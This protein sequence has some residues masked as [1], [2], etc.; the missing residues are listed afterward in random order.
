MQRDDMINALQCLMKIRSITA[1]KQRWR[2]YDN[3]NYHV[4]I[5]LLTGTKMRFTMD[6]AYIANR[7]ESID[8]KITNC[9]DMGCVMCHED[10][11]V[12]GAHCDIDAA[13]IDSLAPYTEIAVGGGNVLSHP[14]LVPLLERLADKK[15]IPSITV[16]QKHF[17][18]E[19]TFIKKLHEHE[20]I[21][22]VGV[23]LA[24]ASDPRL[25]TLMAEIPSSVLHVIAGMVTPS[26]LEQ[27]FDK[28]LRVLV[29][30]YKDIRRG[31]MYHAGNALV[32]DNIVALESILESLVGRFATVSFDNLALEQLHVKEHVPSNVW[33]M[34]YMGEDGHHTFYIDAVEKKFAMSSTSINRHDIGSNSIAQMFKM[35]T[36]EATTNAGGN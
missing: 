11:R 8:M 27:L 31:K 3:G 2:D 6:N 22:G 18:D 29:L 36:E 5:D 12:N 1:D 13:F 15:C 17:I 32:D 14:Q 25:A 26:D 16:H 33:N 9:C 10:S 21:Y 19:F 23:S 20:L 7:P 28:N 4:W 30:G 35:I 24:D 34:S